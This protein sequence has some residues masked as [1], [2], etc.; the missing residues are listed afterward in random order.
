[1]LETQASDGVKLDI[2]WECRASRRSSTWCARATAIVLTRRVG[3]SGR[4]SELTVRK[5]V[6]PTPVNVLCLS[7][8]HTSGDGLRSG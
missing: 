8:R 4:S 7:C 6:E 3:A 2:A 5:L 1:V